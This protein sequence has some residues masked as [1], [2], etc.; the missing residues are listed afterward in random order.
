VIRDTLAQA[1]LQNELSSAIP[2]FG[3]TARRYSVFKEHAAG[4]PS[5]GRP[6]EDETWRGLSYAPIM[7]HASSG[8]HFRRQVRSGRLC[9][10]SGL[11]GENI[12]EG[13]VI[14]GSS[15][16]ARDS[17]IFVVDSRY[18]RLVPSRQSQ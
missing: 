2:S 18:R 3:K 13:S 4:A 10:F 6:I 17:E 7:K 16:K 9:V 8:N 1:Q 11:R 14:V 15:R 12:L 5:Q